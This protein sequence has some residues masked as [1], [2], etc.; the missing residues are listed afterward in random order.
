ME[1]TI[2]EHSM[3]SAAESEP[4]DETAQ[5]SQAEEIQG[6]GARGTAQEAGGT[7]QPLTVKYNGSQRQLSQEEAVA[8]AQKGMNYDKIHDRLKAYEDNSA[9]KRAYS[10]LEDLSARHG[11]SPEEYLDGIDRQRQQDE[12]TQFAEKDGLTFGQAQELHKARQENDRLY[13][14]NRFNREFQELLRE[15]PDLRPGDI[16]GEAIYYRS[17]YGMPLKEAYRLTAGYEKLAAEK[18]ELER[19]LSIR[20]EGRANSG[21]S[22]G[23]AKGRADTRPRTERVGRMSLAEYEKYRDAIWAELERGSKRR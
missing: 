14:E 15:N 7:Y 23:S 6:D 22:T 13:E 8:Y 19:K 20:E 12:I 2:L 4:M 11:I 16:P 9:M 1:E 3:E 5:S 21:L 10:L 17:R 18:A